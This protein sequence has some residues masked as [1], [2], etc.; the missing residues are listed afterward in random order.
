MVLVR[1]RNYNNRKVKFHATYAPAAVQNP[2]PLIRNKKILNIGVRNSQ[3]K[4]DKLI[5]QLKNVQ[6][7][8]RKG[9]FREMFGMQK[10]IY[11]GKPD[12]KY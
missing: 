6:V 2:P 7:K 12:V 10:T 9:V 4:M 3:F 5:P 8:Q 11:P 1:G